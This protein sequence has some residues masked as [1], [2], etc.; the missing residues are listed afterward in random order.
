MQRLRPLLKAL[1]ILA[2]CFSVMVLCVLQFGAAFREEIE[3]VNNTGTP[4]SVTPVGIGEVSGL[5]HA[6]PV[7]ALKVIHWPALKNGDFA[8]APGQS[9]R[10]DY[11][12]DDID[13]SEIY[14]N[15]GPAGV[16]EKGVKSRSAPDFDYDR[17]R[18]IEIT[19]LAGLPMASAP[20][21]A[22][23]LGA[24]KNGWKVAWACLIVFGPLVFS[25]GLW[26]M[27][28]IFHKPAEQASEVAKKS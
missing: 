9:I 14:I 24:N 27:I 11:D 4:I 22:A 17:D 28:K 6:L 18:R 23:A 13:P 26:V 7:T 19:D 5:R 1:M 8:V 10:I 3:I 16:F 2:P 15:A 25:A 12:G 20:V 21:T